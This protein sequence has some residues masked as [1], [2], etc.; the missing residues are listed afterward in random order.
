M[1]WAWI[2]AAVGVAIAIGCGEP[3]PGI[4]T[5]SED[6]AGPVIAQ[7]LFPSNI[8]ARVAQHP[9]RAE[10]VCRRACERMEGRLYRL[11]P[12]D[13]PPGWECWCSR[14]E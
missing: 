7:V 4:P 6:P 12:V 14:E 2:V 3:E 5:V 11:G 8:R 10:R 1:R 13:E 9:E